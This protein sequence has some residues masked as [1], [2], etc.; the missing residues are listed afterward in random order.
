MILLSFVFALFGTWMG[1]Y[2]SYISN[3]PVSFFITIIEGAIYCLS[4]LYYKIDMLH[5]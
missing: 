1:L 5:R 2:L 3:W 4:L